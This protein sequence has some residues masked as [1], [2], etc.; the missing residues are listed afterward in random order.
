MGTKVSIKRVVTMGA[1]ESLHIPNHHDGEPSSQQEQES[2]D[3]T[4]NVITDPV[5]QTD[6]LSQQQ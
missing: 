3:T 2:V 4:N 6:N 1:K 5:T